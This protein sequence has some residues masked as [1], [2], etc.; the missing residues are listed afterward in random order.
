[1][2]QMN[3]FFRTKFLRSDK[4]LKKKLKFPEDFFLQQNK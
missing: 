3:N 4:F 2:N 1:M